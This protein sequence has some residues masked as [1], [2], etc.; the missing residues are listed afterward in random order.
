MPR[1][2]EHD[3]SAAGWTYSRL[4]ALHALAGHGQRTQDTIGSPEQS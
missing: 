3:A 4:E 1:M 2:D